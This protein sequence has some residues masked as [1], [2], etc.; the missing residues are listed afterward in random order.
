MRR[1]NSL[2]LALLLLA[3]AQP[4]RAQ[5]ISA[6]LG[7]AFPTGDFNSELEPGNA[8]FLSGRVNLSLLVFSLQVEL[9]H[10]SWS[11]SETAGDAD[12]EIW[13]PAVNLAFRFIRIGPVRPY[14]LA[15]VVGSNQKLTTG[16]DEDS[17]VRFGYQ[18]GVGVDFKL[19][20]LKPFVEF[21]VVNL[22]GPG[23]LS[24]KYSPLIFGIGIF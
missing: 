24:V 12:L 11:W 22:D 2:I 5:L 20:P 21:R 4:A 18:A 13:Q 3:M 17:S 16:T 14:V 23:D 10:T 19:G 8:L 1:A 15:G 7:P 6:G 9:A